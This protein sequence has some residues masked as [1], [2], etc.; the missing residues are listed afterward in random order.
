VLMEAIL[1]NFNRKIDLKPAVL[2]A[3]FNHARERDNFNRLFGMVDGPHNSDPSNPGISRQ[4]QFFSGNMASLSAT[5]SAVTK[6]NIV[7]RSEGN[8]VLQTVTY[9][10]AQ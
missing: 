7:V 2:V 1:A 5:L 3:G 9:E 8:K 4:P 10:W 6:E